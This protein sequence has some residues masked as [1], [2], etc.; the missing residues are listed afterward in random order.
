MPI[1][2]QAFLQVTQHL[3]GG[4]GDGI[5]EHVIKIFI[6]RSTVGMLDVGCTNVGGLRLE[7]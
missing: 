5:T 4:A 7:A 3:K 6:Q 1:P 2:I